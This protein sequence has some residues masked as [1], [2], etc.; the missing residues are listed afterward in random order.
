MKK[1]IVAGLLLAGTAL[2]C[3]NITRAPIVQNPAAL[4]TTAQINFWLDST[5]VIPTVEYQPD[6]GN[7][8]SVTAVLVNNRYEAAL[9]DLIPA[10]RYSYKI[11]VGSTVAFDGGGFTTLRTKGEVGEVKFTAVGDFGKVGGDA[12]L[13]AQ[14]IGDS[15]AL[16][17]ANGFISFTLGDNCYNS[18]TLAMIDTCW[19]AYYRNA[20]S[21]NF[22]FPSY[23]NHDALSNGINNTAPHIF[24]PPV[25]L[26]QFKH[27][28]YSFDSGNVHF[29]IIFGSW[30]D[31]THA[32]T[33]W[34]EQD[35]QNS[36]ARWKIIIFHDAPWGDPALSAVAAANIKVRQN[37]SPI[38]EANG[39]DVVFAGDSHTYARTI[40]IDDNSDTKGY[41]GVVAGAGAA[42]SGITKLRAPD[43]SF[44]FVQCSYGAIYP[45]VVVNGDTLTLE[46]V[47][48]TKTT[49]VK[50]VYE[51]V[52]LYKGARGWQ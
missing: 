45:R 6:G 4:A 9:T 43:C 33:V 16:D 29:T 17:A 5:A 12:G 10:T 20:Y 44:E 39:V 11:K 30:T 35:L 49:N 40:Y 27:F 52:R 19:L 13:M 21:K 41:V 47:G 23:G 3:A 18:L 37:L 2:A 24:S 42:P 32:Q 22:A 15:I 14:R 25:A 31:L 28:L 51:T 36:T 7:A 34:M 8:L 50:K 26:S 48:I 38:W 1:L 46:A